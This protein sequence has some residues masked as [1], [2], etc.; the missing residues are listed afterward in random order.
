LSRFAD[1]LDEAGIDL[2]G[3]WGYTEG[4]Q[5][6]RLSCVPADADAFRAFAS[7]AGIKCEEGRTLYLVGH[8]ER[9]ALKETFTQVADA[10]INLDAIE[11]VSGGSHFGCFLWA[12]DQAFERLETLLAR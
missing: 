2:L 12:D 11:C 10:G 3:L 1:E 8:D 5:N 7:E 4:N 9:G 6:P